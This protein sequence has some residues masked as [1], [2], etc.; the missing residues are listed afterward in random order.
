[1]NKREL[2]VKASFFYLLKQCGKDTNKDRKIK[3]KC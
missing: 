1:M 3:W 2:V